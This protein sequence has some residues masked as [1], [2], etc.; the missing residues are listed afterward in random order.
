[1]QMGQV[2]QAPQRSH[3]G[4]GI[5]VAEIGI[6]PVLVGDVAGAEWDPEDSPEVNSV[7]TKQCA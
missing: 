1:M 7:A 5:D 2:F 6:N 3:I 4:I